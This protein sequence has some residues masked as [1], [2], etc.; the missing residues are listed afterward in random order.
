VDKS[1]TPP[2][3]ALGQDQ[4]KRRKKSSP[5]C[6]RPAKTPP[7]DRPRLPIPLHSTS[8]GV[9]K[10]DG[11]TSSSL[12]RPRH[13]D[14]RV[15][16]FTRLVCLSSHESKRRRLHHPTFKRCF[17]RPALDIPSVIRPSNR[18]LDE[19]ADIHSL[20]VPSSPEV[21]VCNV[22]NCAKAGVHRNVSATISSCDVRGNRPSGFGSK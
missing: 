13:K 16:L 20:C 19:A 18:T 8:I 15:I 1:E 21:Q 2:W 6:H 14:N 4:Q 10:D 3:I 5:N 9:A 11:T 12:I 17:V 7:I 22:C